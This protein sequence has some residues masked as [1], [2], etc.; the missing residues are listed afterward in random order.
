MW[1]RDETRRSLL[2]WLLMTATRS[3]LFQMQNNGS[4]LTVQLKQIV[5]LNADTLVS[6]FVRVK[7][8]TAGALWNTARSGN[9]FNFTCPKP[10]KFSY[11]DHSLSYKLR[12]LSFRSRREQSNTSTTMGKETLTKVDRYHPQSLTKMNAHGN[13]TFERYRHLTLHLTRCDRWTLAPWRIQKKMLQRISSPHGF[14]P[15]VQIR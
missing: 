6:V 11:G 3:I 12:K 15:P 4:H 1:L 2:R 9:T 7:K 10:P 5:P 8:K 13:L 14:G